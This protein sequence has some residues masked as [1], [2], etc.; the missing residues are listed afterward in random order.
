MGGLAFK[1]PYREIWFC[2]SVARTAGN[3]F[4][5]GAGMPSALLFRLP[6]IPSEVPIVHMC[7]LLP[8]K[9][10]SHLAYKPCWWIV[11]RTLEEYEIYSKEQWGSVLSLTL[12][13]PKCW[14]YLSCWWQSGQEGYFPTVDL[15]DRVGHAVI[16]W[17]NQPCLWV[18]AEL[19]CLVLPVFCFFFFF[20]SSA[21]N[22]NS[23]LKE[24]I[25][26]LYL[27]SMIIFRALVSGLNKL[28][29][30]CSFECETICL[31]A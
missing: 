26:Y 24:R 8:G 13:F 10:G 30:A 29:R 15:M 16:R 23:A 31:C 22:R 27:N 18:Y 6:V 14:L 5:I 25:S 21:H 11:W 20:L 28:Q 4:S 3:C 7:S 12:G 1:S 17:N 19:T 9:Q 2:V